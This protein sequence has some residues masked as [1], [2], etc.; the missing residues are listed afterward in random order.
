MAHRDWC[1]KN[2][3]EC[4]SPCELDESIPCSPACAWLGEDG[5]P[6][7]PKEC[8]ASG[9]DAYDWDKYEGMSKES[10]LYERLARHCGHR[11]AI[12]KYGIGDGC[13]TL[14]CEDCNEVIF[15]TD[16]Y[17]LKGKEEE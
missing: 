11:V 5:V 3:S 1:G 6:I 4:A 16:I 10:L 13:Y 7:D 14:E 15:D 17:D 8:K 2:C 9:C 12:V